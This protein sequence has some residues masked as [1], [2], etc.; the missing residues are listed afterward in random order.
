MRVPSF[1]RFQKMMAAGAFFVCG[2]IVGIAAFNGLASERLNQALL[3]N[4]E[5]EGQVSHYE[6]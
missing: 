4:I 3:R 5:L 6:E 2:A 1:D